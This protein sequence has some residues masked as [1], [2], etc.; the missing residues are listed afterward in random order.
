MAPPRGDPVTQRVETVEEEVAAVKTS[1]L[2]MQQTLQQQFS[3]QMDKQMEKHMAL[4]SQRLQELAADNS[5][6]RQEVRA[7]ISGPKPSFVRS[8]WFGSPKGGEDEAK[9]SGTNNGG[10]INSNLGGG[11]NANW[12]FRK[13]DMP[14]FDG[15]NPDG[16]IIRAERYFLFYRLNESEKL[17]ASVVAL[18]GDALF[19]YQWEHRRRPINCWDEMKTMILRQFRPSSSGSLH[20]QWLALTQV[21]SVMDYQRSFIELA[22]PL[23]NVPE[24]IALGQFING[25]ESEI[26][27][28]VRVLG[29]RNLEH[30]MDLALKLEEKQRSTAGHRFE[31]RST[32][33]ATG[34][35][36]NF[37]P[38]TSPF[39]AVPNLN[40]LNP[41]TSISANQHGVPLGQPTTG[42]N[43]T[44][45]TEVGVS[46][47]HK[48][49]GEVRRLSEKELQSKRE[50]GLC[51][52]CDEKWN[53]GH[54]CRRRELSVLLA[55]E[56]EELEEGDEANPTTEICLNS[57]LGITNPKTLKLKGVLLGTEVIV[58]VDPGATHNFISLAN[59]QKLGVPVSNTSAILE[60]PWVPGSPLKVTGNAK[61]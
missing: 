20:E 24:E 26:R 27:A 31:S 35:S 34:S 55:S 32:T 54:R 40:R 39:Q 23:S 19:W 1:I 15:S 22:A 25:L 47:V 42:T 49:G 41:T 53:V 46:E 8:Q 50:R 7:S 56:E 33:T 2:E 14:L 43:V 18:E 4:I 21:G 52:R 60:C 13:L 30:A 57:V 28:E 59:I 10:G 44:N 17:E 12:R 45:K 61:G 58:M 38:R 3:E 11:M 48:T 16:W 51:F 36:G 9:G 37:S 29:P 6:L 5:S